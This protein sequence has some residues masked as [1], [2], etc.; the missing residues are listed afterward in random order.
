MNKKGKIKK[1][2]MTKTK[3]EGTSK[4]KTTRKK[5]ASKFLQ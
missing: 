1:E 3:Q 4:T 5:L 2:H